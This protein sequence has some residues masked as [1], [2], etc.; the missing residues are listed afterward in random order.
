M[1]DRLLRD[2][3]E[4]RIGAAEGDDRHLGEEQRLLREDMPPAEREGEHRDGRE[5]DAAPEKH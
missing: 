2:V 1:L 5:P 4:H 3:G